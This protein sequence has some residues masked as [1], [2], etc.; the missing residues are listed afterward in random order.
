MAWCCWCEQEMIGGT[1]DC[2]GN[3]VRFPDGE[4]LEAVRHS[5]EEPCHDCS[6][7]PGGRH[8][9]GCDSERC[10]RC[11]GQLISCGCLDEKEEEDGVEADPFGWNQ[12]GPYHQ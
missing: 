9:P 10:P 3:V 4:L 8:H 7:R 1:D 12:Y 6:V 5:G 2:T 11:K